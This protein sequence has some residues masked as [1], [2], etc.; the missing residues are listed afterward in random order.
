MGALRIL[1]QQRNKPNFG[2][3]GAVANLVS[4]AVLRMQNRGIFKIIVSFFPLFCFSCQL[5]YFVF[6]FLL[7]GSGKLSEKDFGVLDESETETSDAIFDGLIGCQ[8]IIE[9]MKEYPPSFPQI[10]LTSF[11]HLNF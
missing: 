7:G 8:K 2:N 11:L 10:P 5:T 9:L 4:T 6:F 3:G 1:S